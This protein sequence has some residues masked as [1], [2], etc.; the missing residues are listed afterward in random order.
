MLISHNKKTDNNKK[1]N[2]NN[3]TN[4]IVPKSLVHNKPKRKTVAGDKPMLAP[5]SQPTPPPIQPTPQIVK[6]I[7]QP[8]KSVSPTP[9]PTI[10][11]KPIKHTVPHIT[12]LEDGVIIHDHVAST[13]DKNNKRVFH[14][15]P[16]VPHVIHDKNDSDKKYRKAETPVVIPVEN[17]DDIYKHN[18][19]S[20]SSQGKPIDP[21]HNVVKPINENIEEVNTTVLSKTVNALN[22]HFKDDII[23]IIESIVVTEF[24]F[25]EFPINTTFDKFSIILGE[26]GFAKATAETPFTLR[27]PKP[28]GIIYLIDRFLTISENMGYD[29]NRLIDM[30]IEMVSM[31][32]DIEEWLML[33]VELWTELKKQ[34]KI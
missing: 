22:D 27:T 7:E 25:E 17:D 29:K 11:S 12:T 28:K 4:K 6:P 21:N 19:P 23:D 34:Q 24:N 14:T 3:E 20:Y 32:G 30:M 8:V 33:I 18:P 26:E 15:D 31:S 16:D 2:N 13:Q 1:D 5:A 10:N 9:Q